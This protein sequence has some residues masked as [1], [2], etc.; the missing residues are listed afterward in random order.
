LATLPGVQQLEPVSVETCQMF[1]RSCAEETPSRTCRLC[2]A[3]HAY[4][5]RRERCGS[6]TRNAVWRSNPPSLGQAPR[7]ARCSCPK[8][9]RT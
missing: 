3:H 9:A 5:A 8:T 4:A 1:I 2:C 7:W 6:G